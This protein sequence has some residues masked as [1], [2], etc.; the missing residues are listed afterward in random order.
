MED[1]RWGK[2][3]PHQPC[4]PIPCQAGPLA[5]AHERSSPKVCYMVS[6]GSEH[7]TVRRDGMIVEEA[8][9]DLFQ[10]QALFGDRLVHPSPQS[11]PD[12]LELRPHPVTAGFATRFWQV[13]LTSR[14]TACA[15]IL[16]AKGGADGAHQAHELVEI[17]AAADRPS[18][19]TVARRRPCRHPAADRR[20][21]LQCRERPKFIK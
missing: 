19:S 11:L 17:E 16:I 2:E 18:R 15:K 4:D 12:L 13:D 5:A 8:C 1:P 14:M 20:Q 6:E 9:Y 7:P 3:V 21:A 10:P